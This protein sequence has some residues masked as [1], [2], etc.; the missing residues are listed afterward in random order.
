[1]VGNDRSTRQ[2]SV[3]LHYGQFGVHRSQI[4]QGTLNFS[5]TFIY[6]TFKWAEKVK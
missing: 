6:L 1:M 5:D 4:L 2:K 3:V